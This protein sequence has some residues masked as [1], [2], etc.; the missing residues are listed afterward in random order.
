MTR[1]F[2]MVILGLALLVGAG[3][4]QEKDKK[5]KDTKKEEKKKDTLP[6]FFKDLELT[7]EQKG[8]IVDVQK[9]YKPKIGD[10]AKEIAGLTKKL[11]ELKKSE[12][13]DIFKVLT[14]AQKKR[15]DE[16]VADAK[17]KKDKKVEEKKEKDEKKEKSDK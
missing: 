4:S 7:D 1:I 2:G 11:N 5:D 16:L 14:E 6:A 9:D 3:A 8:K 17:K 12:Q 10:L 13:S 15:Y